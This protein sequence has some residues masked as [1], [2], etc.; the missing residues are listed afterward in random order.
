MSCTRDCLL[1]ARDGQDNRKLSIVPLCEAAVPQHSGKVHIPSLFPGTQCPVSAS[2][3]Y[4]PDKSLAWV[5]AL[6]TSLGDALQVLNNGWHLVS[7]RKPV[8]TYLRE[9]RESACNLNFSYQYCLTAALAIFFT[10]SLLSL[11][12]SQVEGWGRS[13]IIKICLSFQNQD[14]EDD[15]VEENTVEA[16]LAKTFST[17]LNPDSWPY[18]EIILR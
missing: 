2:S 6:S 18:K 10:C 14:F 7:P 17:S 8:L 12:M 13:Y 1:V 5:V 15:N 9:V 4:L 16:C 11:V 3:L